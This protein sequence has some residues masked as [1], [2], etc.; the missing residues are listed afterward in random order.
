[1]ITAITILTILL[2]IV[3]CIIVFT[4]HKMTYEDMIFVSG[5]KKDNNTNK[6]KNL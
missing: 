5:K 1:M 6:L 2:I 4:L 3:L